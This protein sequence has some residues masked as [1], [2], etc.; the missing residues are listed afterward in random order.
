M[1]GDDGQLVCDCLKRSWWESSGG[2][3][4]TARSDWRGTRKAAVCWHLVTASHYC[5]EIWVRLTACPNSTPLH[6]YII[7]TKQWLSE[8]YFASF[9]SVVLRRCSTVGFK[10]GHGLCLQIRE[11]QG[12]SVGQTDKSCLRRAACRHLSSPTLSTF[13]TVSHASY[14]LA[15]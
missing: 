12:R 1:K 15:H 5:N 13:P 9:L 6:A 8:S 10:L 4:R 7:L 3:G 11:Q 14:M 2:Q